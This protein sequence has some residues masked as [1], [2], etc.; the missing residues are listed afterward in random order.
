MH[1]DRAVSAS[2]GHRPIA[3]PDELDFVVTRRLKIELD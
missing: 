1:L 2:Q 3:I